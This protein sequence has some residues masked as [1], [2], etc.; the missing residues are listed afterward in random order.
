MPEL[1]ASS[2][3]LVAACPA[4][5]ADGGIPI[6]TSG[7]E[8][9][10]GTA[11]HAAL[12]LALGGG[13]ACSEAADVS[14]LA[15]SAAKINDVDPGETV[16][17]ALNG[18]H[19][20]HDHLAPHFP[21]RKTEWFMAHRFGEVQLTGHV[22]VLS[23]ADGMVRVLDWKTGY[24]DG[25]HRDQV[26][27]YAL[28]ALQRYPECDRAFAAVVKLRDK[29]AD[30]E[31]YT[32]QELSDWWA[33]FVQQAADTTVYRPGPAC[34]FCRRGP[35]C[36]AK[37]AALQQAVSALMDEDEL[38][39]VPANLTGEQYC[40]LLDRAR[41]L[42][43]LCADVREGVK[44]RVAEAGG[45]LATE[46]GRELVLVETERRTI[47]ACRTSAVQITSLLGSAEDWD[48]CLTI[49]KTAVETAV[50]KAAPRGQGAARVRELM[51]SLEKAGCIDTTTTQRLEV[52]RVPLALENHS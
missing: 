23:V 37:T 52:K 27:A 29:V 3:P 39:V 51:E 36:P 34:T 28:L 17:L 8:A 12:A 24:A 35:T 2:L 19:A 26:R 11:V 16:H 5:W 45:R 46:D 25:S 22:D 1:R 30:C 18:W 21:D 14:A 15:V 49:S 43:S 6:D 40:R 20:F 38:V 10:L 48:G 32:R 50:R 13:G 42:E 31:T 4:S 9:R 47:R 33:Q 41:M 44:R 7:P